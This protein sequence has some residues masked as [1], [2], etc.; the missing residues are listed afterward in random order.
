MRNIFQEIICMQ[1]HISIWNACYYHNMCVLTQN[2]TADCIYAH[3]IIYFNFL[4]VRK[5][6]TKSEILYAFAVAF[7]QIVATIDQYQVKSRSWR[8]QY[9]L[10]STKYL[11]NAS[12][13]CRIL[14]YYV[15]WNTFWSSV[16][17]MLCRASCPNYRI[18]YWG[19]SIFFPSE[20]HILT[21]TVLNQ[22]FIWIEA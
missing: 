16:F 7:G 20:S 10:F 1:I 2:S 5:N 12:D 11:D 14:L 18:F 6:K 9:A 3:W 15:W 17:N 21:V 4:F 8:M 19:D 13:N 22:L